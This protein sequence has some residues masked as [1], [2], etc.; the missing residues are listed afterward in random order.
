LQVVADIHQEV[1][2]KLELKD[3]HVKREG[4]F[5]PPVVGA[6]ALVIGAAISPDHRNAEL[7]EHSDAGSCA[8]IDRGLQ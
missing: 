7:A 4:L 2:R 1:H 8:P 3:P 5:Y 6:A